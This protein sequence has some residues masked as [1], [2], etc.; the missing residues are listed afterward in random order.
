MDLTCKVALVTGVGFSGARVRAGIVEEGE[1][2]IA[3]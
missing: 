2:I 1:E 3:V